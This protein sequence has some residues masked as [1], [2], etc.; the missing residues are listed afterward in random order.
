MSIPHQKATKWMEKR[1]N[2]LPYLFFL[3]ITGCI[4]FTASPCLS[5]LCVLCSSGAY[6][7]NYIIMFIRTNIRVHTNKLWT[8]FIRDCKWRMQNMDLTTGVAGAT[9]TTDTDTQKQR[10]QFT[11]KFK[12]IWKCNKTRAHAMSTLKCTLLL[13]VMHVLFLSADV[14]NNV[15]RCW[16]RIHNKIKREQNKE[17]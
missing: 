13:Y 10:S 16:V 12:C 4:S 9:T 17:W 14:G 2:L 7:N 5:S 3:V 8:C 15:L 11:S 6:H 1:Q